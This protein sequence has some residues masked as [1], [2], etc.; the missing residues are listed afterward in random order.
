MH[1]PSLPQP[2]AE[3]PNL[4]GSRLPFR[5]S[6]LSCVCRVATQGGA[7]PGMVNPALRHLADIER[8]SKGYG[9][10]TEGVFVSSSPFFQP[11]KGEQLNN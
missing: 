5:A 8:R 2:G 9:G 3:N 10:G 1:P 7:A 4:P 11:Q 6:S